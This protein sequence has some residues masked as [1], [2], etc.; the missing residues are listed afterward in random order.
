M[1]FLIEAGANPNHQ[2]TH[3]YTPL[4]HAVVRGAV[5]AVR[6]ARV[7]MLLKLGANPCV[8]DREGKQPLDYLGMCTNDGQTWT[9]ALPE[10]R[11][12]MERCEVSLKAEIFRREVREIFW[13]ERVRRQRTHDKSLWTDLEKRKSGNERAVLSE[14]NR[15]TVRARGMQAEDRRR[16]DNLQVSNGL[17]VS[18]IL[19]DMEDDEMFSK[20]LGFL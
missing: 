1:K 8:R 18:W 7:E 11:K 14:E 5:D 19:V 3:G 17:D 10:D 12:E 9:N 6:R 4:T 20:C 15:R 16:K 2:D 13:G